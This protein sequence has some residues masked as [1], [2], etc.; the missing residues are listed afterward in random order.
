MSYGALGRHAIRALSH[1]LAMAG[2]SWMNTGEG[3]L[4]DHHR[5]GGGDII[6]QIGPGM[7]GIRDAEGA[8]S[9]ERFAAAAALP[10]V[11]GFELKFHQGAKIRGGHVEAA[12]VTEE[13]ARIRGVP[14]GRA[15]DSPNRFAMLSSVDETLAWIERMRELGGKPVGVKI[16]VGGPGSADE[17]AA[18]IARRDAGPDWITVDGG[19]GG[20][21]ATYREMADTMG[22]PLRSGLVE[23]DDALRRHGVRDRLRVFASGKLYSPDRIALALCFG[24]DAVNVARGLM[25]SVGCI[26]ALKCH[27]NTCPVGVATTDEELMRALVVEEKQY[28]VLNYVVAL[29]AGLAS[30]AAAAGLES[31]TGFERRHAVYLDAFGRRFAADS[32]FPYAEAGSRAA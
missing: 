10:E 11:C 30:L 23:L 28:R 21:G 17:L 5:V 15:I 13:I 27:T 2:G 26:Q 1:G 25:I 4:S 9:W 8:W 32:V 22:L 20:S 3:G 29:R 31:P 24:A 19:E 18:A 6:F 14:A 16:V 7:F 12:K